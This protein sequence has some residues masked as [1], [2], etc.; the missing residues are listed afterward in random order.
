MEMRQAAAQ[1][2][3][4]GRFKRGSEASEA[5]FRLEVEGFSFFYYSLKAIR[6]KRP[7]C[8]MRVLLIRCRRC[9]ISLELSVK[10]FG[11]RN[12]FP[13][14]FSVK[15]CEQAASQEENL[16]VVTLAAHV[17]NIPNIP[18]SKQRWRQPG[19]GWRHAVSR[20]SDGSGDGLIWKQTPG[21]QHQTG[22]SLFLVPGFLLFTTKTFPEI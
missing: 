5:G 12:M 3:F 7:S 8:F 1:R 4:H 18:T 22:S 13:V 15:T 2:C 11:G 20:C 17:S 14:F 19:S 21:S 9:L 10:C 6:G 16:S